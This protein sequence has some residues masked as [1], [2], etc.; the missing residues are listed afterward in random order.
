MAVAL[1]PAAQNTRPESLYIARSTAIGT[2]LVDSTMAPNRSSTSSGT[3]PGSCT[4]TL[5]LLVGLTVYVLTMGGRP[6]SRR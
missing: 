4:G 5:Y 3:K 6:F 1:V 2:P